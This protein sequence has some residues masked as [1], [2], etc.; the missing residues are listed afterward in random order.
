MYIEETGIDDCLSQTK[1]V[2][3]KAIKSVVEG[4][5]YARSLKAKLAH[6]IESLEWKVFMENTGISKYA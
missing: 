6:A 1:V 3:V 4:T 5:N 2:V